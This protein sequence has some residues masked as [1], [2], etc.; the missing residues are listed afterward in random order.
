VDGRHLV[1]LLVEDNPDHTELVMRS[2]Q[3]H[4]V[5]NKVYHMRDGDEALSYL[6]R[7]IT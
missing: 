3:D 6:F 4:R 1:I 2:F 5:A 7:L